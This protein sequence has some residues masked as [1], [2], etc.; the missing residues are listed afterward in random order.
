MKRKI[1]AAII[2]LILVATVAFAGYRRWYDENHVEVEG[3]YIPCDTAELTLSGGELPSREALLRLTQLET[4]DVRTVPVTIEQYEQLRQDFPNCTI[5]WQVP[6]QGTRISPDTTEL[7]ISSLSMDDLKA[8]SHL[9]KL[10]KIDAGGCR[11]YEAITAL[12]AQQP[13][14]DIHY[15][16]HIE[17]QE[18]APNTT[19]LTLENADGEALSEVLPYLHQLEE[20]VFTGT[21]PDNELIYQ[22]M[23]Q[24]P[25][26]NFLWDLSVFGVNTSNT[27][28]TLILSGIPMEG[29][30]ELESYL[31]YFPNLERVEVCDC[32][33]PS[34][35]MDALS[36]RYPDIRFVWTI[37]IG[38]GTL[39]TDA[40]AFIPYKL[41]YHLYRPLLDSDCT[42]LKYCI[43][44]VCL[45]MG[46][47]DIYDFSFLEYMPKLKYLIVAD[48]PCKDFSA[49][50]TLKELIYLE[51]FVTD[52]TQHEI[53]LNL[54]KLEDLNLGTTP[55]KDIDVLRQ[56]TWLKRLWIPGTKLNYLQVAEL[57]EAL[58]DTRI[59]VYADHSTDKGWRQAKNYYDMRDLLGM[60]YME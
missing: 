37:K 44:M 3:V 21:A 2:L 49:I 45:D 47:M 22:M 28:T 55:T 52:F 40:T 17:G 33:I 13:D 58:P 25:N 42:E 11:D 9:T 50:A 7:T 32:G 53:L 38:T 34:E 48:T 10:Q 5:L 35:E 54:T 1:I 14:L 59:V 30:A 8:I 24:Y 29:T 26:V 46:H 12:L 23:C 39:R 16:I 36:K 4:L 18:Y 41:G 57:K 43:D 20:V 19:H 6:F 15:S 56:M 27:A 31:R 51:I 60:F